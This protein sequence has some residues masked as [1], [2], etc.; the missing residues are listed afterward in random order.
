[1]QVFIEQNQKNTLLIIIKIYCK[2]VLKISK[3]KMNKTQ[4]IS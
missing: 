1:M 3:D 4:S 2:F